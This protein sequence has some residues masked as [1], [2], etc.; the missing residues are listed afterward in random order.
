MQLLP[1]YIFHSTN[2]AFDCV[3]SPSGLLDSGLPDF[4]A[5]ALQATT[6]EQLDVRLFAR[7]TTQPYTDLSVD[8][9]ERFGFQ[10]SQGNNDRVAIQRE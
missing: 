2:N 10:I 4:V 3:N 8:A 1:P 6:Q 5:S 7:L 9:L